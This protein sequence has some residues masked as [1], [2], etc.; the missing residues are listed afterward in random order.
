MAKDLF[1][2][3]VREALIKEGW[4]IT[5]DPLRIPIDGTFLEVDIA[6]E[7]ILA[8]E[9]GKEKIAVEVKSFLGKSFMNDFHTAMG[10]YLDYKSA[11][12]DFE[13][14]RIVFLALPSKIQQHPVFNG[15]FVQK[16]FREENVKLIIFDPLINEITTWIK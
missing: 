12:E 1:H 3:A 16:R 13:P 7:N 2:E 6:A 9:R 14:E 5:H 10:Q 4:N 15:N 11:M 8:A